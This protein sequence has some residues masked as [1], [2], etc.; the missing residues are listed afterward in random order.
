MKIFDRKTNQEILPR[1]KSRLAG[2]DRVIECCLNAHGGDI[3]GIIFGSTSRSS[4]DGS[5]LP[6]NLVFKDCRFNYIYFYGL[7]DCTFIDCTFNKCNLKGLTS[8]TMKNCTGIDSGVSNGSFGFTL[9]GTCEFDNCHGLW[10]EGIFDP[11]IDLRVRDTPDLLKLLPELEKQRRLAKKARLRNLELRK[12]IKHGYKVVNAP[13]L[14][15]L[16]FPDDAELIN[17][18]KDKS[19]ASVA[20]VESIHVINDMGVEG[21]V[22]NSYKRCEYRVGELVYP[23]SFDDNPNQDCGH[24]IHFCKDLKSL[25]K[26]GDLNSNQIESLKSQNL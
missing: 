7:S 9:A 12:S 26:Y 19:R 17:L 23:D 4:I 2:T 15:K 21:V 25:A 3:S 18:D 22:N 11:N 6:C 5:A 16:S 14:V 10:F 13:V 24:G 8:I 1:T 20:M